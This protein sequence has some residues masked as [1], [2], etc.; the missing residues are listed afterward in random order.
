VKIGTTVKDIVDKYGLE[1]FRTPKKVIMGGPM[2]G[3]AQTDL[4]VP[5]IKGT[6]GILFISEHDA[7]DFEEQQ[8]IRCAKCVD[9]CPVNLSPTEIIK[10]VKKD[11]WDKVKNFYIDDCIECGACAYACPARI[12][13]VQYIKEGKSA[14]TAR[15]KK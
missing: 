13:L 3:F 2:T 11:N 7:K 6:S 1:I 5:V 9:V 14:I 8:C 12:P 4:D 10:N 15:N